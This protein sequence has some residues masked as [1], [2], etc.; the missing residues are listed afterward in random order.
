MR[1]SGTQNSLIRAPIACAEERFMK[2]KWVVFGSVLLTAALAAVVLLRDW[3]TDLPL[4]IASVSHASNRVNEQL[5]DPANTV[6]TRSNYPSPSVH[7]TLPDNNFKAG[8][9]YAILPVTAT[10]KPQII[11]F[12]S[13]YCAQ[14]YR[15]QHEYHVSEALASS[16]PADGQLK[17]YH[18][19]AF[20][21]L[22]K[23]LTRAWAVAITLGIEKKMSLVLF[24]RIQKLGTLNTPEDI[25]QAFIDNG[26]TATAYDNTLNSFLV[27]SLITQQEQAIQ[28]AKI[29]GVPALL[30]NKKYRIHP[31]NFSMRNGFSEFIR[32]YLQLVNQLLATV[33]R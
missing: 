26:I 30:V 3:G 17:Q 31:E 12:F 29:W 33:D 11:E 32:Q 1:R 20:G 23:E 7:T 14:C 18:I 6:I 24:E 13:F 4:K 8:K 16:L 28:E 2:K 15:L 21:P 22:A 10:P 5:E 25:R 19:S 9:H 27:N